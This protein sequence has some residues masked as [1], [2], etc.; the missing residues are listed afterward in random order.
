[1]NRV[2]ALPVTLAA[3][4]ALAA[5]PP[6]APV[7]AESGGWTKRFD[8]DGIAVYSRG[9]PD[10]RIHELRLVGEIDAPPRACRNVLADAE[11]HPRTFPHVAESRV[12]AQDE[13]GTWWVY[14]RFEFPLVHDRDV[15]LRIVRD[16]IPAIPGSYRIRFAVDNDR[17]PPARDGVVRIQLSTGEWDLL[18]VDGGK[19]TRA[20][21]TA[22]IDPGGL[23]PPFIVNKATRRS[24]PEVIKALRRW[25][26]DPMYAAR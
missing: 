19:R 26:Q 22:L 12:V 8:E 9:I 1:M 4:F 7:A 5:A 2:R 6:V 18:P 24:L 16:G 23:L 25:A 14:S 13:N 21:Y 17:G 20:V 11:A 3:L 10:A 15:T